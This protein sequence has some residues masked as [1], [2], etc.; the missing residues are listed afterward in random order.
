M[1]QFAYLA[2]LTVS[3]LGLGVIDRRWRL[4]VFD[5]PRR[6]LLVVGLAVAFF[7]AWDLAGV[8]LGIFFIG[9]SEYLSGLAVAP[10]VPLEELFFLALLA[11][12]TLILWRALERAHARRA[13]RALTEAP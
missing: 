3:L 8:G 6:A 9:D 10:E 2:G 4:A 5:Q 12:Q 13:A 7:L 11:Y 1:S